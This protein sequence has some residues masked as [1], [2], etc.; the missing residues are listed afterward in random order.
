[1]NK[2]FFGIL[3]TSLL[4]GSCNKNKDIAQ[5]IENKA[6]ENPYEVTF[7]KL[8]PKYKLEKKLEIEQVYNS[9]INKGYWGGFLVA[10]NGEILYEDY[11]GYAN[12]ETKDKIT[13]STPMHV[14]SVGKVITA[15][16]ILRLVDKKI[17]QLD[18]KVKEIITDFPYEDITVRM[19]LNHRSGIPNYA[20][21]TAQ[22]GIWDTKKTLTNDDV[23]HI[24]KTKNIKLDFRP[25]TRFTYCN[26]NY[27]I[28][29]KIVE[30]VTKKSFQEALK[31]LIFEPLRMENTFVF[32][33]LSIKDKVTQSYHVSNK[34]MHWDYL[35]GT[36][37]DKNIYTTPRDLL[38]LDLAL[39]S[40][41]FLSKPI[42]D[43]IYKGYSYEKPGKNNYGLG[44]RMVEPTFASD[45][46]YTFHNGWWRGNKPSYITLR[47]D[48]VTIICFDN[49]NTGL[50][51][52]A[53]YI[54]PLF[55]TFSNIED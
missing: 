6:N 44:I 45:D 53:K 25:D 12:Y 29:A 19:L 8:T 43:Q 37:G 50:A 33:D 26:T 30:T 2:I 7:N 55:G 38:K 20:N 31:I 41:R 46:L 5:V 48:T 17:I 21:F 54:A 18:Q 10:K 11:Q 27:V 16:S 36:Y 14:A 3:T 1:M 40:D 34:R 13:D 32:S 51:Y 52:K 28:L 4:L 9:K 39:Y 42:K 24:L 15:T 35:D 49:H 23:L 22:K 47:K